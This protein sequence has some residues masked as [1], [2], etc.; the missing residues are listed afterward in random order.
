MVT[1]LSATVRATPAR[2]AVRPARAPDERS[3]PASGA[4]TE[5]EV[6]LTMRPKRRWFMGPI[7]FWINSIATIMLAITPSIICW[8]VSSR[9][10]RIGGPA[11]LLTRM[12][13][14][15]AGGQQ[16]LLALRRRHV[17]GHR[18]DLGAGQVGDLGGG[19]LQRLGVA[20]VDHHL[21]AGFGQRAGA[22]LAQPS[23]RG[24]DD[25]FAAGYSQI[26]GC[27]LGVTFLARASVR[28]AGASVNPSVV[29]PG[30][31][32]AAN[33]ESIITDRGYAIPGPRLRRVPE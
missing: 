28:G 12:S 11:L 16:R 26:H 19:R 2:N 18:G 10:S 14:C 8:R 7:T 13:G 23:A 20:A 31:R 30:R 17:G 33:P 4:F 24:A 5:A 22:A 6:M 32:E 9:K 27:S 15:R 29:I 3:R 21:A 25:G 1:F